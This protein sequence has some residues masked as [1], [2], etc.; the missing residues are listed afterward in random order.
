MV[1]DATSYISKGKSRFDATCAILDSFFTSGAKI[2]TGSFEDV[3]GGGSSGPIESAATAKRR[4]INDKNDLILSIKQSGPSTADREDEEDYY[5]P[6]GTT[7]TID[8]QI[9]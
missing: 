6:A 8:I 5:I 4:G 2:A 7:Y 9:D 1:A 3:L